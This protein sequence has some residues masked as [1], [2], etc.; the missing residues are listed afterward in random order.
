MHLI[1]YHY[2]D[3]NSNDYAAVIVVGDDI[4]DGEI[5]IDDNEGRDGQ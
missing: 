1:N 2:D 4:G 3:D 5:Y